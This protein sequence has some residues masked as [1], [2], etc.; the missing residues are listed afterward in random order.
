MIVLILAELLALCGLFAW[1]WGQWPDFVRASHDPWER[2]RVPWVPQP[3]DRWE[4]YRVPRVPQPGDRW[5]INQTQP[6]GVTRPPTAKLPPPRK[7][8]RK[9]VLKGF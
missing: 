6:W 3:G 5:D 4:R 9:V 2:Y 8:L 1:T 7:R